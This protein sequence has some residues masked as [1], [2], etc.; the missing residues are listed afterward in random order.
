LLEF[1]FGA[2]ASLSGQDVIAR[3]GRQGMGAADNAMMMT[4]A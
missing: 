4:D 3:K 2:A 1:A